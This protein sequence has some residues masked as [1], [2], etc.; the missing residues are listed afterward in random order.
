MRVSTLAALF[1]WDGTLVCGVDNFD[2]HCLRDDWFDKEPMV[3][4]LVVAFGSD[5][6]F[7][8]RD[9]R[10]TRLRCGRDCKTVIRVTLPESL[11]RS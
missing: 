5:N 9:R 8:R 10:L 2:G 1:N 6:I 4:Y 11:T 7:S 3:H